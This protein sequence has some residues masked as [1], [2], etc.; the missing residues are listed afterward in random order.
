MA[1]MMA[2]ADV[3][4]FYYWGR[5]WCMEHGGLCSG[6]CVWKLLYC[7]LIITLLPLAVAFNFQSPAAL[8][9][10]QVPG[11][12]SSYR[13]I[14]LLDTISEPINLD[15]RRRLFVQRS[16]VRMLGR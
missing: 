13:D 15:A 1:V 11:A 3:P 2:V 7:R 8:H 10:T 16:T 12:F 6:Y 4:A 14:Y 9:R 5:D